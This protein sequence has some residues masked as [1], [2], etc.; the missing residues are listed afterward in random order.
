MIIQSMLE[1]AH[2]FMD[3]KAAKQINIK[4]KLLFT[5]ID[6]LRR[7]AMKS[8]PGSVKIKD[9]VRLKETSNRRYTENATNLAQTR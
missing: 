2:N 1:K 6:Y 9:M 4:N 5:E 7:T 3:L 8:R